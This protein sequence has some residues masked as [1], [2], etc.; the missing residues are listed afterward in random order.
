MRP[1]WHGAGN[2]PRILYFIVRELFLATAPP[3][4]VLSCEK[5]SLKKSVACNYDSEAL[6][7]D[8]FQTSLDISSEMLE[9]DHKSS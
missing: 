5:L 1:T 2:N 3:G 4:Q 6:C 8:T 7:S 9:R